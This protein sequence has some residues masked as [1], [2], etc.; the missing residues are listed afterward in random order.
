M[1]LTVK[2][3]D[4]EMGILLRALSCYMAVI[5]FTNEQLFEATVRIRDKLAEVVEFQ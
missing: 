2:L 5:P 3:S 1:N 4:E